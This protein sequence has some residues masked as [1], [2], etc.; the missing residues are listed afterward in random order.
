MADQGRRLDPGGAPTAPVGYGAGDPGGGV[1]SAI[2]QL[3][4]EVWEA[5]AQDYME[6]GG[7]A[8]GL[9]KDIGYGLGSTL[10]GLASLPVRALPGEAATSTNPLQQKLAYLTALDDLLWEGLSPAGKAATLTSTPERLLGAV[11]LAFLSKV[12]KVEKTEKEVGM[13]PGTIVD[14]YRGIVRAPG[15]EIRT[16]PVEGGEFRPLHLGT[17]QTALERTRHVA[18]GYPSKEPIV[19]QFDLPVRGTLGTFERPLSDPGSDWVK[20][21]ETRAALQ[22]L[23]VDAVLYRNSVEGRGQISLEAL[24]DLIQK[25]EPNVFTNTPERLKQAVEAEAKAGFQLYLPR[26]AKQSEPIQSTSGLMDPGEAAKELGLQH[27]RGARDLYWEWDDV[28]QAARTKAGGAQSTEPQ[29]LSLQQF[30]HQQQ[31]VPPSAPVAATSQLPDI[32]VPLSKQLEDRYGASLALSTNLEELADK[33]S[34]GQVTPKVLGQLYEG[35]SV[36]N[37]RYSQ[38]FAKT[39][40]SG[41]DVPPYDFEATYKHI[42]GMFKPEYLAKGLVS[43]A[44]VFLDATPKDSAPGLIAVRFLIRAGARANKMDTG[45][46]YQKVWE[47]LD[48]S[49]MWSSDWLDALQQLS[50]TNVYRQLGEKYLGI[51][52]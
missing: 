40:K 46:S 31:A 20:N 35:S 39:S 23:G 28:W 50:P 37:L 4:Q 44:N 38:N 48:T 1:G 6:S 26:I 14:L 32:V 34:T 5:Q 25:G 8:K 47:A 3:L 36:P 19:T 52:K 27:P 42:Q 30:G 33:L 16:S 21:A 7:F 43:S 15:K 51:K 2:G 18:Q 12:G 22:Q 45:S 11:P 13:G 10:T 17:R 29:Q 41:G 49:N 9:A 24:A